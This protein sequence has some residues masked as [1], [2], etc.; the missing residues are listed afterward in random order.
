[1]SPEICSPILQLLTP[2][3]KSIVEFCRFVRENGVNAGTRETIDCLEAAGAVVGADR[4][5]FR[6]AWRAILCSSE[7][8]WVL[9]EDLFT[10]FWGQSDPRPGTQ[11]RKPNRRRLASPGR[12]GK[13]AAQ[14][15]SG[16]G[17]GSAPEGEGEQKAYSGASAVERLKKVDFSQMTQADLEELERIATRLLRRMSYRVARRLRVRKCRETID[18]RR[19]IRQSVS[20]GGEL[21]D[22]RYKG[23]KKEQPK[24]VLLL[25]VSDSMNPYSFFL[26]KFAYVLGKQ[27]KEVKSYIFSTVLVEITGLLRARRISDALRML[28]EITMGW[29]G[30]TKIGGSLRE[31]NSRYAAL[32]SRKTVFIILSDGWD[33]GEPEELAAEM[34]KIRRRV[35]KL[36]WLNP[37]LGLDNY[38]PVTRGMSAALPFVDLFA[39]AH[40]LQSLLALEEHL[41]PGR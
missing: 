9:F 18:L 2:S 1:M 17:N 6:F 38:Q 32:L 10:A 26:L 25:D 3:S 5:T 37:L 23:P 8:E 7:E 16:Y 4:N 14:T 30:G 31:F 12:E 35:A 34:K 15:A 28:S 22:L 24:L 39:P 20:R 40:N 41:R 33:T 19:T 36:I 29:S 13:P 27:S 21:I 11:P